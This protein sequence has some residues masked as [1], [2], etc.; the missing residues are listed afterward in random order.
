M[1]TP[2][3][4]HLAG[5]EGLS[6]PTRPVALMPVTEEEIHLLTHSQGY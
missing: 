1:G 3:L 2:R 5:E 4:R 6:P